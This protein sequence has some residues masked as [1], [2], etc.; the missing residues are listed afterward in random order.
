MKITHGGDLFAVARAHGWDWREALDLS[1][2]IN[3][4]GPSPKVRA[5]VEAALD[6]IPHYPETEP[7]QLRAELA[8]LWAV[9]PENILL[10]NGA[11]DLLH[12]YAREARHKKTTLTVPTF[13]EFHRAYPD[14]EHVSWGDPIGWPDDGL[15]V[16]TQ[17]NSPTGECMGHQELTAMAVSRSGTLLIDESFIDFTT[18]PSAVKLAKLRDNVLV[19]RSLTKFYALPGLRIGALI[20]S[21]A[22][23]DRLRPRR[24][25]WTVNVLAEA[26]ARAAV[27]DHAHAELARSLVAA[28]RERL[29]GELNELPLMIPSPSSANF[30]TLWTSVPAERLREA[31]LEHKILIRVLTGTPGI[32][33]EAVRV[34]IRTPAENTRFLDALRSIL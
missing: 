16:I 29:L 9:G 20:G 25:P 2:S 15:L 4:L 33:G 22:T 1:A 32:E 5:A 10:G 21:K 13:S 6:R 11:T 27:A 24:E 8:R 17:P 26:G 19:L 18:E 14:A 31:L 23:I 3:P 7:V 28:E 30:V 34:A 12:F